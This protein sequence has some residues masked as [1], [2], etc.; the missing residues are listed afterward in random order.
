MQISEVEMRISADKRD[1][2]GEKH[3]YQISRR[4]GYQVCHQIGDKARS[5]NESKIFDCH[6]FTPSERK[7]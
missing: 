7:K 3:H 2:L 6:L 4:R 1:K 5:C